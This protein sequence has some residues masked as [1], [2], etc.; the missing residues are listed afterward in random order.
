MLVEQVHVEMRT[1]PPLPALL[2]K[3]AQLTRST[4][5][6]ATGGVRV[7]AGIATRYAGVTTRQLALSRMQSLSLGETSEAPVA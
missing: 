5:H 1:E 3:N 4:T 2:R 7:A 6:G